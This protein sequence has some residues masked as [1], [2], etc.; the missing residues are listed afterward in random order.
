[1]EICYGSRQLY[2]ERARRS[3]IPSGLEQL[4][5]QANLT[6]APLVCTRVWEFWEGKAQY[7]I[8]GIVI[9]PNYLAWLNRSLL[10]RGG[11]LPR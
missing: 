7:Y 6:A 2:R 5:T 9:L 1:M 10:P 3:C 11:S 8:K 4:Q